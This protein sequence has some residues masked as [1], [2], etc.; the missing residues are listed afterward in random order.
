MPL[1]LLYFGEGSCVKK[2]TEEFNCEN[3][4]HFAVL[5]NHLITRMCTKPI[6]SAFMRMNEE[7][8]QIKKSQNILSFKKSKALVCKSQYVKNTPI[9][10]S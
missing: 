10:Q 9:S 4:L 6:L 3:N 8:F 2:R 7:L 5:Q 1:T